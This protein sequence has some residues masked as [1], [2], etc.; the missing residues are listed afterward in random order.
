[1]RRAIESGAQRWE[2]IRRNL[3]LR[4]AGRLHQQLRGEGDATASDSKRSTSISF[5]L[6][7]L[8]ATLI[9][10]SGLAFGLIGLALLFPPWSNVFVP[11][12]GA[13]L[14][15]LCWVARP[16]L[17]VAPYYLAPRSEYPTLYALADRI[18][19]SLKAPPV[20]GISASAEFG[21]SYQTVGW[22]RA[23]YVDL[24]VPLLA[25]LSRQERIAVIAHELSHGANG[26]PLRGLYLFGAVNTLSN[27]AM[28]IRPTSIGNSGDSL[29]L[30]PIVSLLAIPLE[31]AMLAASETI[32][33]AARG[34]VL[35]VL[36]ESQRAEYLA[37]RLAATVAG[38]D[39]MTASLEKT[40]LFP[41][42]D[43]ASRRH[44]LTQPNAPLEGALAE[45]GRVVSLE[46]FQA[47]RDKS[48][49]EQWQ[50][51]STHP[52]TALRVDMLR[53]VPAAQPQALLSDSEGNALDAELSK[54]IAWRQREVV[55]QNIEDGYR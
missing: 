19:E 24:G 14:V 52:P 1:M 27:W 48:F 26:D 42:I 12:L 47:Y 46:Q 23:R 51:D 34:L 11:L 40:Y 53:G 16:R 32:L 7:L 25:I 15:L 20:A 41:D 13:F 5:G 6:A 54:L 8:A 36:R 28:A 38:T 49:H 18:A 10:L 29:P 55:N 4:L 35:L 3:G 44:A 30:G 45:A 17:G 37:D 43:A 33:W 31:L 21:A 22:R 9:H 2:S 50:V 39:A